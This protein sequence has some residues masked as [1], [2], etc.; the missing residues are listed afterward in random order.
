MNLIRIITFFSNR[1]FVYIS[2]FSLI[3][4]AFCYFSVIL[5]SSVFAS[6][7][8]PSCSNAIECRDKIAKCQEAWDL[9]EKAIK[10][11]T[12]SLK[13]MES[14]IA[15]FQARIKTI[16]KNVS[17]KTAEIS[18]GEKELAGFLG[19]AGT[20]IRQFYIRNIAH[21]TLSS[22]LSATNVG[23]AL[24]TYAY[25]K[26]VTDEDKKV[27][28]QTALSV[29]D[30]E[31]RLTNLENEKKSLA[32]IK[33]ET[34]KR[35]AS[36]REL[37]GEAAAYQTKLTGIISSLTSQQETI[38]NARGGT[39]TTSVG[40]VPLADDPNASPNYNPGFSPAFAGFSFGAYTHKKGMSQ[41]GA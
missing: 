1:Y 26:A 21:N 36:V 11:H 3:I 4:I 2:N 24:R 20:R 14:D 10:P 6:E 8:D 22:F 32:Y 15:A 5:P 35:A 40:D 25:Q 19:I 16:E 31:D 41:Y 34:D 23:L 7:C 9:M 27:I 18:E 38:L 29:R 30:L 13:K 39:F 12:D 17:Q 33:E 28:T 37:I